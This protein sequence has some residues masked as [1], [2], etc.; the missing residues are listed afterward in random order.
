[1][2]PVHQTIQAASAIEQG[3]LVWQVEM[4]KVGVRHLHQFT[5]SLSSGAEGEY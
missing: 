5:A 3:I 1:M 4:N 2:R